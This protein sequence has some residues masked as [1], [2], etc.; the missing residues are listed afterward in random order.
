MNTTEAITVLNRAAMTKGEVK[1]LRRDGMVPASIS[2]RGQE[3]VSISVRKDELLKFLQRKGMTSVVQLDV[4]GSDSYTA[5][6]REIQHAP[7]T[8]EWLHVTFQHVSM[9]EET[10][11]SVP[12]IIHG[13]DAVT[14]AGF[15]SSI[16]LDSVEVRGLPGD[17][18][19]HIEVD[20]SHM[21]AGDNLHVRDLTLPEGIS[22]VTEED[23]LVVSVSHPRVVAEEET[24]TEDAATEPELVGEKDK[25][26]EA[27]A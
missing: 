18:P 3:A 15:E 9:T 17:L 19:Q 16:Q 1:Q 14:H 5:M 7:L 10:T 2:I 24:T 11:A 4:S 8:R 22:L 23:R 27:E 25:E 26:D 21:T 13:R 12:V 20:V 6:V